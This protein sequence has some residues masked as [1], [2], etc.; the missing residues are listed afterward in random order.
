MIGSLEI[1]A[2]I[3]ETV[4]ENFLSFFFLLSPPGVRTLAGIGLQREAVVIGTNREGDES[5]DSLHRRSIGR[6]DLDDHHSGSELGL[7]IESDG[8]GE[9][10]LRVSSRGGNSQGRDLGLGIQS[11]GAHLQVLAD[12][13]EVGVW[14]V[15]ED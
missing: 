2:E 7:H 14:K 12:G 10:G 13:D 3:A 9:G 1:S 11:P 15:H 8:D 6:V 5:L 4:A